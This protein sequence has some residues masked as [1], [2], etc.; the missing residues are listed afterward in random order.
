MSGY[1]PEANDARAVA[2]RARNRRTGLV[3]ATIA[4]VF[5]VGIVVK[6]TLLR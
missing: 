2:L 4:V 6:Y 3:L 5:F 1:R